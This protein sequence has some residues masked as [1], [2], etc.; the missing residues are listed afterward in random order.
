[1]APDTTTFQKLDTRVGVATQTRR[2]ET[3]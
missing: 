2:A 1:M 3:G